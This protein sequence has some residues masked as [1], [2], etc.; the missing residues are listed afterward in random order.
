M[1]GKP[2]QSTQNRDAQKKGSGYRGPA[3][4]ARDEFLYTLYK[5]V[6]GY[7]KDN[8]FDQAS[9][10]IARAIKLANARYFGSTIAVLGPPAAGKTTLLKLL[11]DSR[12]PEEAL[13]SYSKTEVDNHPAIVTRF[14]IGFEPGEEL[15][16]QFKVKQNSDVGGEEYIRAQHWTSVIDG[17][18]IIIYLIDSQRI[19]V[20]QDQ[21]YRDRIVSDFD[22]IRDNHQ[23]LQPNFSVVFAFNKIDALCNPESFA[24]FSASHARFIEALKEDIEKRWPD[25]L[26]SHLNG[27]IFLSLLNK[28]LRAFT[29]HALM[30]CLVGEDLLKL[31]KETD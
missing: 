9:K 6:L 15:T 4:R 21:P 18:A 1:S 19:I 27:G 20:D 14:N 31:L 17:A 8:I 13:S 7:M 22:W 11:A 23:Y 26:R 16:F 30:S 28:G 2:D 10:R 24:A 25:H 12:L 3:I 29:L 5:D